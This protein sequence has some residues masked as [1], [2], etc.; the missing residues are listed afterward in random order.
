VACDMPTANPF[1]LHIYAA[2]AEEEARAISRRTKADWRRQKHGAS[3][4]VGIADTAL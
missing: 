4:W 1:I 2:V 3:S